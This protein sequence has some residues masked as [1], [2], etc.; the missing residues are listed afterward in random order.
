MRIVLTGGT[1]AGKSSLLESFKK[2]GF[3][4]VPETGMQI[5]S[6][7][8]Q[9]LGV[10]EQKKWR[11]EN[12]VGFFRLIFE[13]QLELESKTKQDSNNIIFHD[14]GIHDYLAFMK[15]EGVEPPKEFVELAKNN[16][17]DV[18]FICEILPGFDGRKQTGRV[19]TREQS[20]QLKE[21]IQN[22]YKEFGIKTIFVKD[23]PTEERVEFI[24][25]E[26][27]LS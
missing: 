6:E 18:A 26:L 25:K 19:V 27:K 3:Q 11:S 23:M 10:E 9:K 21:L 12:T 20:Y 15:L 5:I 16:P 4:T 24:K 22:I 17:Y 14:R 2:Q 7:I 13:R 1:Y 8:S